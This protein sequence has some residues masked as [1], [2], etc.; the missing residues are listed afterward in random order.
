MSKDSGK[1]SMSK[2]KGH[3]TGNTSQVR[4]IIRGTKELLNTWKQENLDNPHDLEIIDAELRWRCKA[5]SS[6]GAPI[7]NFDFHYPRKSDRSK[8]LACT[9]PLPLD[10]RF[11]EMVATACSRHV[12]HERVT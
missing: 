4:G 7:F 12:I 3:C 5:C 6:I 11:Q 10:R 8:I 9:Q 2:D 1:N